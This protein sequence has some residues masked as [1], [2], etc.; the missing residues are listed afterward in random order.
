[1]HCCCKGVQVFSQRTIIEQ[2]VEAGN[3]EKRETR[4]IRINHA[5]INEWLLFLVTA[6]D[7]GC[8]ERGTF[9]RRLHAAWVYISGYAVP[10]ALCTHCCC[11]V[12]KRP[13]APA[14]PMLL[15]ASQSGRQAGRKAGKQSLA[16]AADK[17]D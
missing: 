10:P 17:P 5:E 16:Q 15:G 14:T 7:Y 1:M 8:L 12:V 13:D 6:E 4:R 3:A 2:W 11:L 9:S